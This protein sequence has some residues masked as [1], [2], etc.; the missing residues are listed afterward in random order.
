MGYIVL[1]LEWNQADHKKSAPSNKAGIT[2]KNEIIQIGAVKLDSE[3]KHTDS[4]KIAVRLPRKRKLNEHVARVINMSQEEINQGTD[5][6]TAL[7]QFKAWCGQDNIFL[8]WG[9]DDISVLKQNL[10]YY[11]HNCD[12]IKHWY[13]LQLIFN[14]QTDIGR[15]QTS[16]QTA[17]QHLGIDISNPLHDALNDAKYTALIC[18]RLDVEQGI[19]A[20][21]SLKESKSSMLAKPPIKSATFS[22]FYTR[23]AAL[24][25]NVVNDF[26][27]PMCAAKMA[28]DG[29]WARQNCDK[30]I[31]MAHC[32]THGSYFIR[33]KFTKF[34][35]RWQ[36]RRHLYKPDA[37]METLYLSKAN[38]QQT[39][40]EQTA[41]Y[42][43]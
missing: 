2:L 36:V 29:E 6:N 20:Y 37:Q 22:G 19:K 5:F 21:A 43:S 13:N 28:A 31:T 30:Y 16:L 1:D 17:A 35:G 11:C 9:F 12:W 38:K 40:A 41:L 10:E 8:T 3:L 39:I 42:S 34:D 32:Q 18:S 7:K 27:C 23:K 4:F 26:T 15:R 14:S 25:D 24:A 33:V